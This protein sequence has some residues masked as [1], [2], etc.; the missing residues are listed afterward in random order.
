M[1]RRRRRARPRA[2][3]PER[4]SPASGG[5]TRCRGRDDD[6][7]PGPQCYCGKRGCIETFLSGPGLARD[8]ARR[9]GTTDTRRRAIVARAQRPATR[10]RDAALDRYAHRMA[11]ALAHRHQ[12]PRSRRDRARRRHVERRRRST[13]RCRELAAAVR[14]LRSRGHASA[15]Q[16]RRRERCAR[17]RLAVERVGTYRG[18]GAAGVRSEREWR[19]AALL[20]SSVPPRRR[21]DALAR[22]PRA[23]GGRMRREERWTDR[24]LP[25]IPAAAP[26]VQHPARV[27]SRARGCATPRHR[28]RSRRPDEAAKAPFVSASAAA[29][30]VIAP[31]VF[32]SSAPAVQ[33]QL[34]AR[35]VL[36]WLAAWRRDRAPPRARGLR[37]AA[38]RSAQP[39]SRRGRPKWIRREA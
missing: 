28:R 29:R 13:T 3:G 34:A 10:L 21:D 32:P 39:R 38:I 19:E 2:H 18:R 16:A 25:A 14:L 9:D 37:P 31:P 7:R 1:R 8:Y 23:V 20:G 26:G 6:E 11:R 15:R 5:T 36:N 24:A 33:P 35:A 27:P 17:R 12:R 30:D 22:D 4:A